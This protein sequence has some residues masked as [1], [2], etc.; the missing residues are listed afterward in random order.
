[1]SC[2]LCTKEPLE[3]QGYSDPIC[4]V[5]FCSSHKVPLVVLNRHTDMPTAGEW[6]H[7]ER[8]AARE[9][10]GHSWRRPTSMREHF[11]LHSLR[12]VVTQAWGPPA[13]GPRRRVRCGA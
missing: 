2:S 5:T 7:I 1:M 4:W 13:Q 9:Y 10:P 12:R 6:R 3:P 11:S 8:V